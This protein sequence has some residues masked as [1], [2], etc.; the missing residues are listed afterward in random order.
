MRTPE[1]IQSDVDR[2]WG[3]YSDLAKNDLDK[4]ASGCGCCGNSLTQCLLFILVSMDW[5]IEEGLYD[6]VTHKLDSDLLE[7]IGSY[8]LGPSV[9]AGP[10][11]NIIPPPFEGDLNGSVVAGQY[12]VDAVLWT[13]VSGPNTATI[14][15]PSTV[16]TTITG[17][18]TGT[19][20]FMLTATDVEGN[21]S[22]D[23]VSVA[24]NVAMV[25]AY[26]LNQPTDDIPDLETI[27]ESPFVNFATGSDFTITFEGSVTPIYSVVAYPDTETT[28]THWQ[29]TVIP[30]NQG[31]IG[32]PEDLFG[33]VT[34]VGQFK[35]II[36]NYPTQFSN[37]IRFS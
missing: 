31:S 11:S 24:V 32:S 1:Q 29:D 13:Q 26:Y 35:V 14:T 5:R 18:D 23:T 33:S 10:D 20:V 15:S 21:S 16:S 3:F 12:P 37:P 8:V 27:M 4:M 36:T 7:I 22:R 9:Y 34:I 19:Y 6:D 17:L 2:G 28:K 30:F 25:K